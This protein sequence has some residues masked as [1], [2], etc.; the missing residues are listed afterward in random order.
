M[1]ALRDTDILDSEPAPVPALHPRSA[2]FK[3][4]VDI[5]LA[6]IALIVALP[7]IA[8]VV[9]IIRLDSPGPALFGQ[10]RVGHMG[11]PFT[12][13]KLRSMYHRSSQE[14]HLQV[15]QN[16]FKESHSGGRYKTESDPRVTRVGKYLRRS[17]LDELPQLFNVLRGEMSLVGPRPMMHY[18]RTEYVPWYFE[19]EMMKPGITG[20]WQVSGR[21][22]LS[23]PQMMV[24]DVR[25]VRGWSLWLDVHILA[26]TLTTIFNDLRPES[27]PVSKLEQA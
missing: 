21:Q 6:T 22:R 13:W 8:C 19:R 7:V 12:L 3:R 25:Y 15:A 26:R 9:L 17:S 14:Y 16:W 1:S 11:R 20:L 4:A 5:V 2:P 24:L 23:A 18:D 10:R 27:E